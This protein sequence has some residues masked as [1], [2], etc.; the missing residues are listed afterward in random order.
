MDRGK[1]RDCTMKKWHWFDQGPQQQVSDDHNWHMPNAN[2]PTV[3]NTVRSLHGWAERWP[4]AGL[5]AGCERCQQAANNCCLVWPGCL[6]LPL[7]LVFNHERFWGWRA[8]MFGGVEL[9]T[10][11]AL[12]TL[13]HQEVMLVFSAA[14]MHVCQQLCVCRR[15]L[16]VRDSRE[17]PRK[18]RSRWA[19]SFT[20][21]TV[22]RSSDL[23][24]PCVIGRAWSTGNVGHLRSYC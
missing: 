16:L 15:D 9:L 19:F 10:Q 5:S 2:T 13:W 3:A 22:S 21:V 8:R 17:R 12:D 1:L 14:C 11:V 7:F 20:G 18:R 6:A 24:C 4:F 23:H